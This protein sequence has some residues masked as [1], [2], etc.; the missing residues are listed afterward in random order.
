MK[1]WLFYLFIA[2]F[3]FSAFAARPA[4]A[5]TETPPTGPLGE[6]RG[7][8]VN[9]NTGK[10]VAETQEVMLHILDQDFADKDMKHV[11]SASDGTFVFTD[12]PFD[13]NLQ[14]AVM[15]TLWKV[16]LVNQHLLQVI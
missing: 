2:L 12:I 3:V 8:V 15:A 9:H 6:V 14:F 11:Q 4:L 13:A 16:F 10:V 7:T 5:Q 1:R